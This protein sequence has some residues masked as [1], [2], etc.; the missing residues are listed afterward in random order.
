VGHDNGFEA[1]TAASHAS[2][3]FSDEIC[4]GYELVLDIE[5]INK[6]QQKLEDKIKVV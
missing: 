2:K 6:F 4:I 5:A 3:S 1:G